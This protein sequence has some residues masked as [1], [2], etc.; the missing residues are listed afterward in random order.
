MVLFIEVSVLLLP[1]ER[2]F[3]QVKDRLK[4]NVIHENLCS[5]EPYFQQAIEIFPVLDVCSEARIHCAAT[6]KFSVYL[7]PGYNLSLKFP[8]LFR[9]YS[10]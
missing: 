7:E 10:K 4:A 2:L 6:A 3:V 8:N 1:C 9:F 5:W